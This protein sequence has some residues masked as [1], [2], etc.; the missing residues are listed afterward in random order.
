MRAILCSLLASLGAA[1]SAQTIFF[2][3]FDSQTPGPNRA[4]YTTF[5]NWDVTD[6]TVDLWSGFGGAG[7]I[8]DLDGSSA[9]PGVFATKTSFGLSAGQE[10]RVSFQLAG[11]QRNASSDA[12]AVRFAGLQQDYVIGANDPWTEFG[13]NFTP[14]SNTS[15]KLAFENGGADNF[16]AWLDEVKIEAVPEPGIMAALGLGGLFAVRRARKA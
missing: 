11:N 12:V 10:Y 5:D 4:N 15:S 8:V 7:A 3:N 14:V 13:F 6:G 1:A 16:G 9:N 2:D